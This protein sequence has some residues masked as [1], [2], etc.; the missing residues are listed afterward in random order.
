MIF[1][2]M[3]YC[4]YQINVAFMIIRNFFQKLKLLNGTFLCA[5]KTHGNKSNNMWVYI[6][7]CYFKPHNYFYSLA[8]TGLPYKVTP[9]QLKVN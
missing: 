9:A 1:H 3:F 8:E 6:S 7:V 4:I 5:S 2:N